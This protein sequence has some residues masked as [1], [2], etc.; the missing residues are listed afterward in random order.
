MEDWEPD[1]IYNF[2]P[3]CL[4]DHKFLY[5][6]GGYPGTLSCKIH[7]DISAS[8]AIKMEFISQP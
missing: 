7:G 6:I 1:N 2:C 5:G 4:P 3:K 8:E